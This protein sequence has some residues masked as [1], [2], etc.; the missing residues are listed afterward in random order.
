MVFLSFATIISVLFHTPLFHG[1]ELWLR[2]GTS[3]PK[4]RMYLLSQRNHITLR[5]R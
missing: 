1:K 5:H 3:G 2:S 4:K